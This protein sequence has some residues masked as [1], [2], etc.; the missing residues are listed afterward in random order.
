MDLATQWA[1]IAASL[2]LGIAVGTTIDSSTPVGPVEARGGNLYAASSVDRAL[3]TGL[4]SAPN[5]DVRIGLTFRDR[6]GAVCRTFT[7]QGT[8]GLACRA[9]T[10]W[11]VRG[12]FAAPEGQSAD[13]GMAAGSDPRLL[14]MVEDMIAGEPFDDAQENASKANLWK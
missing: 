12:L 7:A 14:A 8:D 9:G 2:A 11:K 10:R 6:A 4:A 5:G 1:A 3:D 13:N